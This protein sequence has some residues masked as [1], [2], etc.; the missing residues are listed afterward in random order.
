MTRDKLIFKEI[1]YFFETTENVVFLLVCNVNNYV[2]LVDTVYAKSGCWWYLHSF[3]VRIELK[4][5]NSK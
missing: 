4:N 3:F 1:L 2:R 5:N